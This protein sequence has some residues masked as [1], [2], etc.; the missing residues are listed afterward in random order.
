MV[1]WQVSTLQFF[2]LQGFGQLLIDQKRERKI[3]IANGKYSI[4]FEEF[5]KL[6]DYIAEIFGVK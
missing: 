6:D 3:G 2:L 4:D 1:S 5:D